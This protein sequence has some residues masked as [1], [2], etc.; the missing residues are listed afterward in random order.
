MALSTTLR[1]HKRSLLGLTAVAL[2]AA[3]FIGQRVVGKK[4]QVQTLSRT[5]MVHS[6]VTTGRVRP[7]RVRLAPMAS[8][9]VREFPVREGSR[10]TAGQLLVQL[11]DTEANAALSNA[12]ALLAQA[13]AGRRKL[14]TITRKESAEA[15]QVA[16]ARLADAA[17]DLTRIRKLYA[18]GA[19]SQENL[20]DAETS[21]TLAQSALRSAKAQEQDLKSGGATVRNTDAAI[22]QARAN[23]AIAQARAHYT[24]L[25]APVDGIVIARRAEVGDA[26]SGNTVVVEIAATAKTELV[27]EPDE[28]NLSL[29]ALGQSALAS[30][31]AFPDTSFSAELNF[32][33]PVVDSRRGT[34]EVRF[35]VREPP[36]YLRPDMTVSV[37]IEVGR[38]ENALVVP[39]RSV[40]ALASEAPF[41]YAVENKRVVRKDIVVGIRD[42]ER[43]EVVSGI[44]EATEVILQPSSVAAGDRVRSTVIKP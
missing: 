38:N 11:D 36:A 37:D 33:A 30:A 14:R 24:R 2:L 44:D 16:Q 15:L 25:V 39:I 32:I 10:V 23:V 1:K 28:R 7:L 8:G 9:T 40:M 21:N 4:V 12:N 41:V 13:T 29:L 31:E 20:E 42:A 43:V 34:I 26:I 17:R 22:E 35:L 3:W 19:A 6:V 18:T 5:V 27:V